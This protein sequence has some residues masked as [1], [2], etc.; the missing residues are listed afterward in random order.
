MNNQEN[1][2]ILSYQKLL[3]ILLSLFGLTGITIGISQLDLGVM[4]VWAAL[5]VAAVKST[6]VFLYF[7]HL[8]Y[9]NRLLRV[10]LIVTLCFMAILIGFLF[11]DISFR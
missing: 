5:L 8:R 2:H 3:L 11:L 6:L 9:E 4:N 7:M 1:P 10:G